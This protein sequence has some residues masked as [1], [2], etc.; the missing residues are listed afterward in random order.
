MEKMFIHV[1]K[2][3]SFTSELQSKYVN[4]IVF[5]KDTQ[6]IWTHGTFYAIPEAYKN[7]ITS[8]ESAVE[9]LETSYSFTAITDG[10]TTATAGEDATTI[11]FTGAGSTTVKVDSSGVTITGKDYSD[12]ISEAKKAGE[13]AN[14]A[15]ESYK[16]TNN[17]A[18]QANA[19]AAAAAKKAAD[20]AN[21]AAA[22]AL[23]EAQK[24][25]ASVTGENA[26]VVTE[27]TT[28]KVSLKVAATQGE[29]VTVTNNTDGLK[30][31]VDLSEYAKT[32][33]LPEVEYPVTDVKSGDKVLALDG[34]EL[35]STLAIKY[36][37]NRISIT[38]IG[39]AEI[40]GFDASAFVKDSFLQNVDFDDET[41]DL[42][43]T[44]NT[45]D[46]GAE[47]IT[48]N[49][50][51]L[52]DTYDGANLKLS[53]GYTI[54]TWSEATIAAGA[55]MDAVVA[56]LAAGVKKALTDAANAAEAGVTKFGTKTGEITLKATSS[57]NGD[58]NLTMEGNE[59][60]AAV[61]GLGTAAYKAEGDFATAAQGA[62]ADTAIQEVTASAGGYLHLSV[63][64]KRVI[65]GSL[66]VQSVA[67]ASSSQQGLAEASDVKSYVESMFTW[68]EIN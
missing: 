47:E 8:L 23:A 66:D 3:A 39:G 22:G 14:S 43:F 19:E 33:E 16:T 4:S 51:D 12:E 56:A 26:I 28:P 10:K 63:A 60:R 38:G 65:N 32:A 21:T 61:V 7:K 62:L 25:V 35:T 34:T 50:E 17:A 48:V 24:K 55:S 57:T 42:T 30:V 52:V 67:T 27:G 53:G 68:T 54:G 36:A 64:D 37:N 29:K 58:V 6:E 5:I 13:D 31:A 45:E 46:N 49:L 15:L 44:F 11:K 2:K 41:K 20:D 59:L 18:V 40:S 9:A 1:A